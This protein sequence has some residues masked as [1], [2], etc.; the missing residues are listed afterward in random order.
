MGCPCSQMR[1]CWASPPPPPP[2]LP[3][4]SPSPPLLPPAAVYHADCLGLAGEELLSQASHLKWGCPA[5]TCAVCARKAGVSACRTRHAAWSQRLRRQPALSEFGVRSC[6]SPRRHLRPRPCA[7]PHS[8]PR[9][10]V[11]PAAGGAVRCAGPQLPTQPHGGPPALRSCRFVAGCGRDVVLLRG[12][13]QRILRGSPARGGGRGEEQ[14]VGRGQMEQQGPSGKAKR[15]AFEARLAA[16]QQQAA[17]AHSCRQAG[18]P[19]PSNLLRL[20]THHLHRSWIASGL[21]GWAGAAPPPPAS[22]AAPQ[23]ER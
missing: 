9:P 7:H 19:L 5:H 22:C 8:K 21:S 13:R 20:P 3:A 16:S 6:V 15:F 11:A 23:S 18:A 4:A 12:L 17:L 2:R 1:S 14:E 10:L